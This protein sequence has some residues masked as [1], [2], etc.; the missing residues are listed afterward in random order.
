MYVVD[1]ADFGQSVVVYADI[2]RRRFLVNTR[3]VALGA[4]ER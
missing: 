4:A 2:R 3:D 1:G